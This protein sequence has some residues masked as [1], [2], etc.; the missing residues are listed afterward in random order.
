MKKD[1]S[2]VDVNP[3]EIMDDPDKPK[4]DPSDKQQKNLFSRHPWVI[5]LI[6]AIVFSFFGLNVQKV[7]KFIGAITH[8]RPKNKTVNYPLANENLVV[9]NQGQVHYTNGNNYNNFD[10]GGC[11]TYGFIS[12]EDED[13]ILF[14]VTAEFTYLDQGT[15][16]FCVTPKRNFEKAESFS[17]FRAD[18]EPK[19]ISFKVTWRMDSSTGIKRPY[20]R[21]RFRWHK[22][23]DKPKVFSEEALNWKMDR[24]YHIAGTWGPGGMK[25]YIDGELVGENRSITAGPKDF[26][27]GTLV[28]NNDHPDIGESKSPSHC[29]VS[30]LQISNYQMGEAEIKEIYHALPPVK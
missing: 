6:V 8:P 25:L 5:S 26:T 11:G 28:I 30:K 19:N 4:A 23:L 7:W 22:D 13:V 10:E 12:V 18:N 15:V 21:L 14:P 24:H 1:G 27:D 16:S 20:L 9:N 29:I 17:L 2:P 3:K